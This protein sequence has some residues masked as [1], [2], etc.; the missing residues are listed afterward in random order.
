MTGRGQNMKRSLSYI[1]DRIEEEILSSRPVSG[2][3][4]SSAYLLE[5]KDK[6]YLL[7]VND[8]PEAGAM[9][10]AEQ[11]GLQVLESTGTIAV[12][13]VYLT[14]TVDGE[15]F[16]LMDF[17]ESKH[18]DHTDFERLGTHLAHLHCYPQERFGFEEDNFIGR[19]P[20]SNSPHD[21]WPAF[22]WYER[23]APQCRLALKA[24]RLRPDE[25]PAEGKALRV[26]TD[27]LGE[28]VKPSLL[29]GDLWGGNYLE[30]ID[31]YQLYYLLV[32]L[33]LFGSGYYSS[34]AAILKRYF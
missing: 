27:I 24:H 16:L 18:P 4:I 22:Y 17:I 31:L 25:I 13:H 15:S 33:N 11:S 12:P 9:F 14:E 21:D 20:Q 19:L 7:K 34:V 30:K 1:S 32:H 8:R 2:G 5:T 23:I 26:F 3:S 29:H 10:H 6:K 28:D